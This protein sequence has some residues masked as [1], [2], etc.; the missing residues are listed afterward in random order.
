MYKSVAAP[1]AAAN[2]AARVTVVKNGTAV[3][4]GI[5]ATTPFCPFAVS[6][7]IKLLYIAV[8]TGKEVNPVVPLP[9]STA[10]IAPRRK[11]EVTFRAYLSISQEA[12][13]IHIYC[14]DHANT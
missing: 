8:N 11:L 7:L 4:S 14:T 2:K 1:P 3:T 5:V 9:S 13:K 6:A 10:P 12:L